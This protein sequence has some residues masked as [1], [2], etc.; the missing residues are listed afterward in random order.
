MWVERIPFCSFAHYLGFLAESDISIAPLEDY[1]FNE[2]K[3]NIKYLEASILGIPSVCSARA[4]FRQVITPGENGYLC[5][6]PQEWVESITALVR[7]K[8]VREQIGFSA[9]RTVLEQYSLDIIA[10]HQMIEVL[11]KK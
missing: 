8:E 10:E 6:T 1:I 4:S 11:R 7:E 3:S 9:C 2:A 5:N